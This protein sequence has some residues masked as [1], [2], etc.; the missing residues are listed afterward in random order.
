MS[1]EQRFVDNVAVDNAYGGILAYTAMNLTVERFTAIHN[2][3]YGVFATNYWDKRNDEVYAV[4]TPSIAITNSLLLNN[5]WQSPN[6]Y[7]G[8]FIINNDDDWSASHFLSKEIH[9]S[10]GWNN[11]RGTWLQGAEARVN[12][13]PVMSG[14]VD[15]GMG[16]C[17]VWI[18]DDSPMKGAGENG[19]DVGANILYRYQNGVL[20]DIPLWDQGTGSFPCGA[21]VSGLNDV[22]G[23][24]CF[25]VHKRLNV[26][27]ND[28]LF[29][30]GYALSSPDP[31]PEPDPTLERDPS[32]QIISA[33]QTTQKIILDGKLDECGWDK[34]TWM[35]FS[36]SGRSDNTVEFATLWDQESIYVAF[37][38]ADSQLESD[39][40]G[41]WQNDGVEIYFDTAHNASTA[42]DSDD[43]RTIVD[44]AGTSTDALV[45]RGITTSEAGYTVELGVPWSALGL[46]PTESQTL[47]LLVANNDRDHGQ[48]RQFDWND[49]IESGSFKRPNLWGDVAL[50][51]LA[52]C[53]PEDNVCGD[54]IDND[55]DGVID[56]TDAAD[57][58]CHEG[59][60]SIT[61][62]RAT[63]AQG[64][65]CHESEASG[66]LAMLLIVWGLLVQ[67]RRS[68]LE[69][70]RSFLPTVL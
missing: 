61:C 59:G 28:C 4:R 44:I 13:P 62:T 46:S 38:V 55:C 69:G 25:D 21:Q 3:G 6:W 40:T 26:N 29:P 58:D 7:G 70:W 23:Q 30:A 15:P 2:G 43:W 17:R 35:S 51:A 19:A 37:K 12:S 24:S 64:V 22:A 57:A 53:E 67:C 36:N 54:G 65:G 9:S 49:L 47:G 66:T 32:S 33:L 1:V 18:P 45:Q 50:G 34:A 48:S 39:A 11:G 16:A 60:N 52:Q 14:N 68:I 56:V 27:T 31:T 5:G 8:I 42:L 41:L 63:V 10:H 20:T